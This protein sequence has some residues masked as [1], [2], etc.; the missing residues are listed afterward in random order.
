MN[1]N[2]VNS[3]LEIT[4]NLKYEK[5]K[6]ISIVSMSRLNKVIAIKLAGQPERLAR[7][8]D[9]GFNLPRLTSR[10]GRVLLSP[11]R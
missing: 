11:E 10:V 5:I 9:L 7:L 2:I 1:N 4:S 8:S 3:S 6:N